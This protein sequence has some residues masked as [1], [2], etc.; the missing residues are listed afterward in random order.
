MASVTA[1]VGKAHLI[2]AAAL[3]VTGIAGA[4][5]S[6]R[7][8]LW[9]LGNPDAGL[10]PFVA[11]ALLAGL[12]G[13]AMFVPAPE[14]APLDDDARRRLVSYCGAMLV[15]CIGPLLTGCL[16]AFTAALFL[17][18]RLGERRPAGSAFAWSLGLSVASVMV[19]RRVLGVPLPDPLLDRWLGL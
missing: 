15:L 3:C 16:V 5:T 4:V 9:T 12:A 2:A 7:M 10:L 8:G 6:W 11:S 13:A 1:R 18:L 19:F 17:A 14:T